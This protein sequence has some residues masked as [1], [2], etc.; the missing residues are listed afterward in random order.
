M[1]G[2]IAEEHLT[3]EE[4]K[5]QRSRGGG[6]GARR[7]WSD[8]RRRSSMGGNRGCGQ[9]W[10][11]H[12]SALHVVVLSGLTIGAMVG[13]YFVG[14]FSGRYVGFET[15]R[16][17]SGVEVPKLALTDDV[18]ERPSQN[19][20]AIY[21]KL[22]AP[23]LLEEP[24]AQPAKAQQRAQAEPPLGVQAAQSI[25]ATDAQRIA[26]FG[27]TSDV[28]G[29]KARAVQGQQAREGSA[30]AAEIDSLFDS[31][32]DDSASAGDVDTIKTREADTTTASGAQKNVRMLGGEKAEGGTGAD[33]TLGMILE[34]RL[35]KAREGE[36][37]VR[38]ITQPSSAAAQKV[39]TKEPVR[40]AAVA[41]V[42]ARPARDTERAETRAETKQGSARSDTS[43]GPRQVLPAGFFA[44]V[45]APKRMADAEEVAKKL[46]KSGFPVMIETA[47]VRGEDFYRVLVGPEENKVQAD[48]LVEQLQRERYLSGA[49]F[50]RRVK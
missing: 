49:P 5:D 8:D 29:T 12:L 2:S 26:Q 11:L 34:E 48:R 50:I 24:P 46:R 28:A 6:K 22:N 36:K 39:E 20:S 40:A 10:E 31:N 27:A 18:A 45:A 1:H 47:S 23:A 19:V 7:S 37:N 33:K 21:D 14:F 13:A 3:E 30:T 4:S 17:A 16:S 43:T 38:A 41:P 15:A 42:D 32:H 25:K 35:A 44:Q 9:A